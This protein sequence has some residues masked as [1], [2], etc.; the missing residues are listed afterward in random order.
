MNSED[1][2]KEQWSWEA[3]GQLKYILYTWT[4]R[5]EDA[6]PGRRGA[7][8]KGGHVGADHTRVFIAFFLWT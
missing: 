1:E 4:R 8:K 7:W 3:E 5:L 6:A 2:D